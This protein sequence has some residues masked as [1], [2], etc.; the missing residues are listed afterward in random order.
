MTREG[1]YEGDCS[2]PWP[3]QAYVRAWLPPGTISLARLMPACCPRRYRASQMDGAR[4]GSDASRIAHSFH[5]LPPIGMG[6][7]ISQAPRVRETIHLMAVVVVAMVARRHHT[8]CRVSW[9]GNETRPSETDHI[10]CRQ[11]DRRHCPAII[12]LWVVVRC[13]NPT[14]IVVCSRGRPQGVSAIPACGVG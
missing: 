6:S 8:N 3:R 12:S 5:H 11:W 1:S 4:P 2:R 14:R 13:S 9:V 7:Y 10:D